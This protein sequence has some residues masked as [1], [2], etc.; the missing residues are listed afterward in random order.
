MV[1]LLKHKSVKENY[2][3]LENH[4]HSLK[5]RHQDIEKQITQE[6]QRPVPDANRVSS[7]KRQKLLLKDSI[8]RAKIKVA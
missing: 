7:L 6:S 3:S 1:T 5:E 8:E 2:M 4:L